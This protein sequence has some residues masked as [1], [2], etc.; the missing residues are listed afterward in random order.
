V[1]ASR[2]DESGS[3]SR[4]H[5]ACRR[6]GSPCAAGSTV[7]ALG[8]ILSGCATPG[9]EDDVAGKIERYYALHAIEEAGKC[10]QPEIAAITKRKVQESAG[11]QTVLRIRYSYF[12]DSADDAPGWKRV[13]I[14]PRPCTGFAERDF[15]L[16]RQK[17]GYVVTAMSG[18]RHEA[19]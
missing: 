11:D 10:P 16:V 8:L 18:E 2:L 13:L 19:P 6:S 14:T 9:A 5:G 12:D 17:T 3:T 7:L 4:G 1:V 15:T